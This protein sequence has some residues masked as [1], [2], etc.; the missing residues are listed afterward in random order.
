MFAFN[1]RVFLPGMQ[2]T[3]ANT[4]V[5]LGSMVFLGM[6]SKYFKAVAAGGETQARMEKMTSE[7]WIDEGIAH[8][9]V[10]GL[11]YG[12]DMT[13]HALSQGEVSVH[14]GMGFDIPSSRYG[15]ESVVSRLVGPWYGTANNAASAAS[16][17]LK[18]ISGGEVTD[19]DIAAARRLI[20]FNNL[21]HIRRGFDQLEKAAGSERYD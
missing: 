9:G 7:Q 11:L 21:F 5:G 2:Q 1:N 3:D 4:M 12:I 8:S 14:A 16:A 13:A 15:A 17:G 6:A 19:A 18:G 20:P 10:L